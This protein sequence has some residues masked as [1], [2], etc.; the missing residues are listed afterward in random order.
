VSLQVTLLD[1]FIPGSAEFFG[2]IH[3]SL[4]NSEMTGLSSFVGNG[5][6]SRLENYYSD[7]GLSVAGTQDT[8]AWRAGDTNLQ[9]DWSGNYHS[10]GGPIQFYA[11]TVSSTLS[12]ACIP[13]SLTGATY[14]ANQNSKQLGWWRSLFFLDTGVRTLQT[15]VHAVGDIVLAG[16]PNGTSYVLLPWN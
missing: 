9:V 1:P 2:L 7:D 4:S 10:H 16:Q 11:D 14:A 5:R 8:F 6:I 13:D 12:D 15:N 3:S